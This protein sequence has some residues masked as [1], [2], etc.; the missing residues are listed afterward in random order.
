MIVPSTLETWTTS[1]QLWSPLEQHVKRVGVEPPIVSDRD[2]GELGLPV[3]AQQ[4]PG[5]DVGVVLHF[6][7]HDQVTAVD[8]VPTPCVRDQVDRGGRVCGEDRLLGGGAEPAGDALTCPFVE[9][10]RLDG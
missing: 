5:D 9:L 6:G 8:V 10:G 1:D 3:L 7:Q 2:V 4:L